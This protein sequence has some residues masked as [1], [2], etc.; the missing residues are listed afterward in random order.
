MTIKE[1]FV[2]AINSA[3]ESAKLIVESKDKALAYAEIAKALSMTGLVKE[4]TIPINEEISVK[5]GRESLKEESTKAKKA[6]TK[7]IEKAAVET[8][9]VEKDDDDEWTEAMIEKYKEDSD[10]IQNVIDD[11]GE[12]AMTQ[13]IKD[14]SEK[15][16]TS[17]DDITLL[18]IQAF[19]SY[20]KSLL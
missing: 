15:I 8:K 5:S 18:N 4:N 17:L 10:F 14:F 16:Y 2:N 19:V 6:E 12:E 9:T 3:T 11:Y 7:V 1:L 20:L 13:G